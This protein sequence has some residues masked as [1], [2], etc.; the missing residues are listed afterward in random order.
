M[1]R[2]TLLKSVLYLASVGL[3][4]HLILPQLP[5]IERSLVLISDSSVPLITAAFLAILASQMCYA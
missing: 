2:R 3:A 1:R 5:G 4:L